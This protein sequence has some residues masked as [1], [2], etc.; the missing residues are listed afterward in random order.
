MTSKFLPALA[1]LS[2]TVF[3]AGSP[4]LAQSIPEPPQ[5]AS[6]ER[7][8]LSAS[9][10][11]KAQLS[12]TEIDKSALGMGSLE[13]PRQ[14]QRGAALIATAPPRAL[15]PPSNVKEDDTPGSFMQEYNVNWSHWVSAQA[16]RWFYILRSAESGLGIR[17][18]CPRAALIQ[19]TCYADGSIGNIVLKQSSGVPA[20]DRLQ[21]EALMATQ[22][23]APFPPGT[24][25]KHITLVQG[26]ES[27]RKKPGERDFQPGSFGRD[28]PAEVVRQWSRA[29]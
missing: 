18:D 28:F 3:C 14:P 21:V 27:H 19:F 11:A 15:V 13:N 17:F 20:Y 5:T 8:Q 25:R 9:M 16:D 29:R 2:L 10:N 1:T 24:V 26:W 7:F 6:T 22:P 23:L 12:R 4:C